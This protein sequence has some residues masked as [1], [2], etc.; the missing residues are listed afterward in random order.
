MLTG[1]I[2]IKGFHYYYFCIQCCIIN[3]IYLLMIVLGM[4]LG[5]ELR[6]AMFF[7]LLNYLLS[8]Y[9][10]QK[11]VIPIQIMIM[12]SIKRSEHGII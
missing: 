8:L 4:M 3:F 10:H 2:D 11:T 6:L 7:F 1:E 12:V 9:L 5:L